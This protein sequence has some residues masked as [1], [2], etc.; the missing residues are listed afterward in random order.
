VGIVGKD[1]GAADAL[2]ID[3]DFVEPVRLFQGT[4]TLTFVPG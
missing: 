2:L 3:A 4:W 1:S